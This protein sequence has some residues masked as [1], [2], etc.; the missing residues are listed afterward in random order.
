MYI[1]QSRVL[2]FVGKKKKIIGLSASYHFCS[3]EKIKEKKSRD[4]LLHDLYFE[5]PKL[6]GAY[7]YLYIL[8]FSIFGRHHIKF[9]QCF[10][11]FPTANVP[12]RGCLNFSIFSNEVIPSFVLNQRVVFSSFVQ[13]R[14][15]RPR[16]KKVF[17]SEDFLQTKSTRSPSKKFPLAP[18]LTCISFLQLPWWIL[19]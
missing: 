5:L 16:S 1:I 2:I 10:N 14:V 3:I 15:F 12:L 13:A 19:P 18:L 11:S 6:F 8:I 7:F 4:C 9:L 17:P